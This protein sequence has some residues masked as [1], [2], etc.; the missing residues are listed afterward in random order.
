M[1]QM[2]WY[3]IPSGGKSL[4]SYSECPLLTL[5]PTQ[6]T[7]KWVQGFSAEV[8]QPGNVADHS[9]PYIAKVNLH[10]VMPQLPPYVH[11]VQGDFTSICAVK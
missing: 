3:S 11:G 1:G 9:P 6:P 2:I 10:D 8:Q 7:V 5:G 4:F